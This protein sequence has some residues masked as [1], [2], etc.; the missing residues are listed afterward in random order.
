MRFVCLALLL[1]VAAACSNDA[2]SARGQNGPPPSV[3]EAGVARRA[4]LD[5]GLDLV[6]QLEAWESVMVHS[7]TDGLIEAVEFQEGQEIAAGG[8]LFRL[9]DDEQSA[10]VREAEAQLALAEQAF[11]RTRSLAGQ[12]IMAA[13]EMDEA[14]ANRDAARARLDL[15]KVEL[16]RTVIR[17]PFDGVLGARLVSPG[18]RVNDE[19]DLV[20]LEAIDRLRLAFAV[21]E[22][23]VQLVS[24]D[25]P[26]Q[27]GVSPYPDAR[28]PG[29]VYFVAPSLDPRS[30]QLFL[31]GEIPNEDHRLRPGMFANIR[32][33]TAPGEE[34]IVIPDSALISD[35]EGTFVYRIGPENTAERVPVELGV[36]R[37]G[38]VEVKS[39]LAVGDRVVTAGTNKVVP[40]RAVEVAEASSSPGAGS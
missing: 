27:I 37:H 9:R 40:G 12:K 25:V 19:T 18:T 3:V 29:K 24:L 31:K 21:P 32:L 16:E 15:A 10:R 17:A 28:F 35:P 36:H 6:G 13:A 4:T 26:L 39:G 33:E 2:E 1:S 7:E 22:P 14:V 38:S 5:G 34:T 30:R 23:I 8:V 11:G 20:R